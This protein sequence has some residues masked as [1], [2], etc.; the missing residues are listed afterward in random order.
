MKLSII[1]PVYNKSRREVETSLDSAADL[2]HGG[3]E[4]L[5]I[6]DGSEGSLSAA[7]ESFAKERGILYFRK[8]NGG[9]SSAR[10]RGLSLAK[11]EYIIF[12]DADDCLVPRN[13]APL[14][15]DGLEFDMLFFDKINVKGGVESVWTPFDEGVDEAEY[16]KAWESAVIHRKPGSSSSVGIIFRREFLKA[17]QIRF[18]ERIIQAEDLLFMMDVLR[19]DPVIKYIHL[20][21]EII[22]YSPSTAQGRWKKYPDKMLES[23]GII[24]SAYLEFVHCKGYDSREELFRIAEQRVEQVYD[25]AVNLYIAGEMTPERKNYIC[26]E[27]EGVDVSF[28]KEYASRKKYQEIL[29]GKWNRIRAY[30]QVKKCYEIILSR[31]KR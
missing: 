19:R 17:H 3:V 26:G 8:E 22:N 29:S 4:A 23:S 21:G 1:I 12:L 11:G 9:V 18:D 10:N 7:Y 31:K 24:D 5:L 20:P 15:W 6:D 28:V 2:V 30:A 27:M 13:L 16:E 14:K 25:R